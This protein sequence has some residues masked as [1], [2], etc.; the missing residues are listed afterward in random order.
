M[1]IFTEEPFDPVAETPLYQQLYG[2]LQRAIL[3][4]TGR[5]QIALDAGAG[6]HG[7]KPLGCAICRRSGG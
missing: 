7:G 4:V 5:A 2:R 3:A 1:N 6:L